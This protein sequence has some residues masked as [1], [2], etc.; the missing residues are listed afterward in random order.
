M[1]LTPRSLAPF[2]LAFAFIFMLSVMLIPSSLL[3]VESDAKAAGRGAVAGPLYHDA[4]NA[5]VAEV[6]AALTLGNDPARL[7]A[8]KRRAEYWLSIMERFEP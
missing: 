7:A 6:R 1:R 4:C 2:I 3:L 8:C 5:Y